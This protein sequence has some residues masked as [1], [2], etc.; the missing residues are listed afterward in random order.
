M[1]QPYSGSRDLPDPGWKV[2]PSCR[3]WSGGHNAEAKRVVEKFLQGTSRPPEGPIDLALV[4]PKTTD[5]AVY[6]IGK[7]RRRLLPTS[8]IFVVIPKPDSR[9]QAEFD[10]S[11]EELKLA[12]SRM[13]VDEIGVVDLPDDYTSLAYRLPT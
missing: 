5:E 3:V 8:Q 2:S 6:F 12:I 7:L 9:M 4:V 10:G 11:A 1:T 13:G